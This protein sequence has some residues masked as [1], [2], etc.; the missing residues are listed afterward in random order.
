MQRLNLF[1]ELS[2]YS[3]QTVPRCNHTLSK[4]MFSNTTT[5]INIQFILVSSMTGVRSKCKEEKRVNLI[6]RSFVS[7]DIDLPL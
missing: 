1:N 3:R 4:E 6:Y 5:V 7:R 2:Q